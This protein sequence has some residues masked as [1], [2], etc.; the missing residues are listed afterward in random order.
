MHH[1]QHQRRR[2]HCT[3]HSHG[4]CPY[5]LSNWK[6][7]STRLMQLSP[8]HCQQRLT[9]TPTPIHDV[10]AYFHTILSYYYL[11]NDGSVMKLPST[12]W[13]RCHAIRVL[14]IYTY[15]V[16][17][18]KSIA[19]NHESPFVFL[20]RMAKLIYQLTILTTRPFVPSVDA[21]FDTTTHRQLSSVIITNLIRR[22]RF[23][24][25][26]HPLPFFPS[27]TATDK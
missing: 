12:R 20:H 14:L 6:I 9:P 2:R 26:I 4:S 15:F 21:T 8:Q 17:P 23:I 1:Q 7:N 19:S 10:N 22:Q 16:L 3:S 27:H 24:C 11:L 18:S 25:R 13:R 5:W